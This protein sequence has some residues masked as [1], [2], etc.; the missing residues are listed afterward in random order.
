MEKKKGDIEKQLHLWYEKDGIVWVGHQWP[1][2]QPILRGIIETFQSL[3][4]IKKLFLTEIDPYGI[5]TTQRGVVYA[6]TFLEQNFAACFSCV[7][8]STM[9]RTMPFS[10]R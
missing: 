8:L 4:S 7:D 9:L 5:P 10:S 2:K 1:P 3:N 6:I